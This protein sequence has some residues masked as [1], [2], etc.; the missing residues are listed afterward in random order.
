M[1]SSQGFPG[2]FK[3]SAGQNRIAQSGYVVLVP[4]VGTGGGFPGG[5][6]SFILRDSLGVP[7]DPLRMTQAAEEFGCDP[8]EAAHAAAA[9][10]RGWAGLAFRQGSITP[11]LVWLLEEFHKPSRT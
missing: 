10:S 4:F 11:G 6:R 3:A 8:A 2:S 5:T 7:R 9:D 1:Q